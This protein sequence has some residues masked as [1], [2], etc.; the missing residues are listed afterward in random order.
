MAELLEAD[1]VIA[2]ALPNS[3]WNAIVQCLAQHPYREVAG[4]L[5]QI[6]MQSVAALEQLVKAAV[7]TPNASASPAP[8]PDE[9]Q[10]PSAEAEPVEIKEALH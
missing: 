6:H 2:I 4:Y 3:A 1:P 10:A 8:A 7:A 9:R 5:A